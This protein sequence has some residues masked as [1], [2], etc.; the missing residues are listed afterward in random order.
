MAK[1]ASNDVLDGSLQVVRGATR[2][3]ALAGQ[4]AS[5]AAADAGRLAEAAL[6][7]GDFALAA[8]DFSGRKVSVA[9][10][11]GLAVIANGVA[12]HVALLDATRL[13]YVTTCP[14]QALVTGGVVS[15]AGWSVE[16]G[17]PV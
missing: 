12:D 1:F 17:A 8:G 13:L 11:T 3:V 16:I 15:V 10:K 2:L 14:A 5:Y 7:P 9:G 4:P 6:A